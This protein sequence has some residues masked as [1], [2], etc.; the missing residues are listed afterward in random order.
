MKSYKFYRD[1]LSKKKL[2]IILQ[3][4]ESIPVYIDCVILQHIFN[5]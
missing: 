1:G 4:R 2:R 3:V 5:V